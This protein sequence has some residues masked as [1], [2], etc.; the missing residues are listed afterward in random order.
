MTFHRQKEDTASAF[1][2]LGGSS[3]SHTGGGALNW[4][5]NTDLNPCTRANVPHRSVN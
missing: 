2:S 5:A 4:S 1:R 3:C